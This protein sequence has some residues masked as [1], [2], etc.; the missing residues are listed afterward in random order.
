MSF[1]SLFLG[2]IASLLLA[3]SLDA[4][5]KSKP[6]G[7]EPPSVSSVYAKLRKGDRVMVGFGKNITMTG[8]V[9]NIRANRLYIDLSTGEEGAYVG[10]LEITKKQIRSL[11]ILPPLSKEKLGEIEEKMKRDLAAAY[12]RYK[13]IQEQEKARELKE[14]EL[15]KEAEKKASVSI[16]RLTRRQMDLLEA[17]PIEEGWGL[18]KRNDIK[19][20]WLILDIFPTEQEREFT[21]VYE[22]WEKARQ[23]YELYKKAI[24]ELQKDEETKKK[25]KEQLEGIKKELEGKVTKEKTEKEIIKETVEEE[26]SETEETSS[27]EK[28]AETEETPFEEKSGQE[29]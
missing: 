15:K 10:V 17:F 5:E 25:D 19:R 24:E 2:V 28:P 22:E 12:E 21:R 3:F 29:K 23:T 9:K 18:A 7:K 26:P 14:A 1:R 16:P 11:K 4:V 6:A 13:K 27:Q 20:R 8:S